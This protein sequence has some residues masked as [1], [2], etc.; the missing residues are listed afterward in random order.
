MD[1]AARI[2]PRLPNVPSY[3]VTRSTEPRRRVSEF[4]QVGFPDDPFKLTSRYGLRCGPLPSPGWVEGGGAAF[5]RFYA[6][7]RNPAVS[8]QDRG[9]ARSPSL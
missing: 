2:L 3:V 9:V 1:R 7:W 6:P 5:G 4:A 8:L